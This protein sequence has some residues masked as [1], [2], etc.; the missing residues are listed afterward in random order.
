MRNNMDIIKG[1]I[2]RILQKKIWMIILL[3]LLFLFLI[4]S[5]IF[6]KESFPLY[7]L[8]KSEFVIDL[9]TKG[10]VK[11]IDSHVI[12]SP[13]NIWGNIRIVKMIPEGKHVNPGDFLIQFDT[14]EFMQKLREAE[15]E[16][17][18]AE[19]NHESKLANIKKQVGEVKS[20]LKIEQFNLEQTRLRAKN[21]IYEAENKRKEIEY[22]LKKAEISHQQ[23]KEK[24]VSMTK[25]HAAE[26]KQTQLQVEQAKIKLQRAKDDLEK[27]TLISPDTGLVVYREIWGGGQMEKVKV[28]STPWRSQ[29]LL[30][31]PDQSKMKVVV[32]INEVDISRIVENQ[33]VDITLDAIVDTIFTGI[34]SDIAALA[35]KDRKTKKNVFNIEVNIN[36]TDLRL[37]PGMTAHCKIIVDIIPDTLFIPIDAVITR[38]GKTGVLN[39]SGD[40][41]Q[42]KTGKSNSNF[43]IV[44]EGLNEGDEIRLQKNDVPQRPGEEKRTPKKRKRNS[45]HR[46]IIRG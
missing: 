11:A 41:I 35:H 45:E 39:D 18:T 10:E 23:L 28:G 25:I 27:L 26:L 29:P 12:K 14:A 36:E 19:A 30:E 15:N 31:I 5:F 2:N 32:K 37:K 13:G 9:D 46:I 17:A 34:V 38:D 7:N 44:E 24:S 6:S 1:V 43:I 20:Q 22:T 8:T 40:F 42:I 4:Y 3:L 16:V 33:Q 21:A